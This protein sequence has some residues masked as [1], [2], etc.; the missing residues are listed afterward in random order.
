M[1]KLT[2]SFSRQF[3]GRSHTQQHVYRLLFAA[4]II[5]FM[6]SNQAGAMN[7]SMNTHASYRQDTVSQLGTEERS[8]LRQL[9][10]GL[11]AFGQEDYPL[12]TR[13]LSPLADKGVSEAQ[14][15]MGMMADAGLGVEKN[16][17][18]AFRWYL[19][20]ARSGHP[21]AQHNLAVAYA[22]GEGVEADPAKAVYWWEQAAKQGNADAQYNLGIVYAVGKLG[23]AKDMRTAMMWWRKAALSGDGMAQ[24]NLGILYANSKGVEHSYCEAAKWWEKSVANGVS[25]AG[26]ALEILKL[27]KDYHSCL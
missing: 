27:R 21:N 2:V 22:Q 8:D 6:Y 25:Q 20:A 14:F 10:N 17:E 12:A 19:A 11:R 9:V 3:S 5:F 16:V 24:Y 1:Q 15:Y 13:L 26:V 7:S 23:V 4:I 18:Q